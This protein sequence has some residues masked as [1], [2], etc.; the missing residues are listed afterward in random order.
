L[1]EPRHGKPTIKTYTWSIANQ[2]LWKCLVLWP[3]SLWANLG[4][5]RPK[6]RRC[7][8]CIHAQWTSRSSERPDYCKRFDFQVRCLSARYEIQKPRPASL[9]ELVI[10]WSV[11]SGTAMW[12]QLQRY[13]GRALFT[14]DGPEWKTRKIILNPSFTIKSVNSLFPTIQER[15]TKL[16][17][18]IDDSIR[19]NKSLNVDPIFTALTL[20]RA[21]QAF[22]HF[23][24]VFSE[25]IAFLL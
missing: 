14:V 4:R 15:C 5:V 13:N 12:G 6:I 17:S 18:F 23:S 9:V 16:A 19:S 24:V 7:V 1:S 25:L 2:I 21:L 11:V 8:P 10:D 3:G 22:P 20:V